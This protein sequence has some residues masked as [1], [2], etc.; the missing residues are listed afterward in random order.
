M[1]IDWLYI[2]EFKNL[3]DFEID[4]DEKSL[5][6]VLI[7]ENGTGK[8]NL[9]EALIVIFRDLHLGNRA[10]FEYKI[11]YEHSDR[12][13]EIESDPRPGKQRYYI[14]EDGKVV[15]LKDFEENKDAFLPAHLFAYY[16][17]PNR[18]IEAYFDDHLR[19]FYDA[20]RT[21][22]SRKL[23][24]LFLARH[25][26]SQFVLQAFYAFPTPESERLLKHFL[27]ITGLES[28]LFELKEPE[29]D[30]SKEKGDERFWYATGIVKDFLA[31]VWSKALAPIRM[32]ASI[33]E[34]FY[35]QP[36]DEER[37]YLYL[38]DQEALQQ[39]AAQY[40]T[41]REFFKHLEST[42][43]ADL[44]R[45]VRTK[46]RVEDVNGNVTFRELSEGEQQL[47]TV[48][49]LLQFTKGEES[50]FLLDEPDTHLNPIWKMRYLET[51]EKIVGPGAH[52]SHLILLTHD[53]LTIAGL[54]RSQVQIFERSSGQIEVRRPYD[55]PRGKGVAGVLTE[56][57]GL[58]STLD[59]ETQKKLD[60]R[61]EL[62][63]V[64][65][66]SSE[67]ELELR[68]LTQEL[69]KLGFSTTF[70]DALYERFVQA[71]NKHP[72][73][74]PPSDSS[75][76]DKEKQNKIAQQVLKEVLGRSE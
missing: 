26:H 42:Y 49:G 56:M 6:T 28:V 24:P 72:E 75:P 4:L 46:V 2:D 43:I 62:L 13:I 21:G 36:S 27:W 39:V 68:E 55:D 16:S 52:N 71:L 50:L 66:R 76:R 30:G 69:E 67:Q 59:P 64:K 20:Q 34:A 1:R 15:H 14:Q 22:E 45:E 33:R 10:G 41:P 3:R 17:G 53:P 9:I 18:R 57:F 40:E 58:P 61:N 44:V 19:D 11:R 29:W 73:Y 48:L 5:T 74:V 38:K 35:K 54:E 25:V 47:L 70:R 63:A 60:E 12:T 51:I 32:T 65:D 7:G 37:L 31:R 23:R 8:S